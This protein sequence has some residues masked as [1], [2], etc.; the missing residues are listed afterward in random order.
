V[1]VIRIIAGATSAATLQN[2]VLLVS[3]AAQRGAAARP[4]SLAI[5]NALQARLLAAGRR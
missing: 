5:A 1:H 2:E 3:F 4:S